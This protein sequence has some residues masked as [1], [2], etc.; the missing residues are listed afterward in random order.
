LRIIVTLD[1]EADNQWRHGCPLTTENVHW[2]QP[3]QDMCSQFGIRPTYL[4]TSEIAEDA[5]AAAYLR[6]LVA[7]GTAEVGAHLHPWTTPPFRDEAGLTFN[8]PAHVF[9]CHLDEELLRDKL[10]TLT[11]QIRESLGVVPTSFRAG[12]F[13]LDEVGA[14]LL[15][16]L[17]YMVDSSVTPFTSWA[18]NAGRPGWRG[19]PDFRHHAADPF[20]IGGTGHPGLVELPVT[21]L[22]TY[23]VTRRSRAVLR[24]WNARPLRLARRAAAAWRRPQ[25]LWLRPRPEYRSGDLTALLREAERRSLPVAVVMFHSSELMPGGSPY[26]PTQAAVDELLSVLKAFFAAA[27]RSGHTFATLTAAARELAATGNLPTRSL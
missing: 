9:P 5:E 8:D 14:R 3:F 7:A 2:W 16:E 10:R 20:R 26:R 18:G 24:H 19:G 25:P 23:W 1:T 17:G 13:G 22:P 6:S 15:A 27:L 11:T 4:I 12:R 21:I